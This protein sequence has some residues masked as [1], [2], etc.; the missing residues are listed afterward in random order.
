MSKLY[1]LIRRSYVPA[2]RSIYKLLGFLD[3]TMHTKLPMVTIFCYHSINDDSWDFSISPSEFKNQIEFLSKNYQFITLKDVYRYIKGEIDINKPSV[4]INF[5]D[6]YKDILSIRK[7][8]KEKGIKPTVFIISKSKKLNRKEMDTDRKVLNVS[9]IKKLISDGWEVG[10]HTQ[11]HANMYKLDRRTLKQE[12]MDSKKEL[13]K[14]LGA[15][16]NYIAYPKGKYNEKVLR[17][18]KNAG[19]LLGLSMD[20]GK[21]SERIDPYKVPRI[22]VDGTHS[23]DEFKVLLGVFVSY[24]R[25]FIM[26]PSYWIK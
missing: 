2:R 23:F 17:N 9:E 18:V 3:E 1:T 14:T 4:V 13:E 22:G 15:P 11:T 26:A 21:I 24:F 20:N 5:D 7:F 19:Y 25:N 8:L 10:S 6:G 12:V 16:I